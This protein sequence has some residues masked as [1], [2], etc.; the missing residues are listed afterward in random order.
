MFLSIRPQLLKIFKRSSSP[1]LS[2]GAIRLIGEM[3][4]HFDSEAINFI[5]LNILQVI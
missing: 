4:F 2:L 3:C 5:N 1:V